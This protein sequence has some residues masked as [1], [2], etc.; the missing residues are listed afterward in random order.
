MQVS[1]QG[2]VR[3]SRRRTRA[4]A[5]AMAL[6]TTVAALL[7]SAGVAGAA[8][9]VGPVDPASGF[10]FSYT[11]DSD[12]LTLQQCQ[13]GSA[14]CI[15]APRPD[16]A[17]PI[18]VPD[19][20]SPDGEGFWWVAD[21]TVPNAGRGLARFAKESAFDN[22]EISLGHQVAFSRIRFRFEGLV[23]GAS[24]RITHPFGVT[25]LVAEDDPG[26]PGTGRINFTNDAGCITPPCGAF[27]AVA[28]DPITGLL[29]W[30]SSAPQIT[31]ADYVGDPTI[32]HAVQGSPEGTNFVQ[33][34]RLLPPAVPGGD[35]TPELVG[36]TDTFLVQGKLAG[37]PPDPAPHL[38]MSDASLFL[39]DRE[40]GSPGPSKTVTITNHGTADLHVSSVRVGG[41]D[42]SDF[43]IVSEDCAGATLAPAET[44]EIE[45][46][47]M[48]AH[49]GNRSAFIQ[50]ES[51]SLGNPHDVAL[52]GNGRAVSAPPGGSPAASGGVTTI[53]QQ[54]IPATTAPQATVAGVLQRSLAVREL[55]AANRITVAR[56]RS[57]GL[58]FA[59]RLPRGVQVL[60]IAIYRER[61]GHRSGRALVRA[62]R[63]PG[64]SGPYVVHMR[65]REIVRRLRPGRY[66]VEVTP[67]RDV[68]DL[69]ATS[70]V[71]FQVVP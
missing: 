70:R 27:P 42:A 14:F 40:V 32:E 51:D 19:N 23:T 7:F 57:K 29:R 6:C 66:L 56:L 48:A 17:A 33:L 52:Q 63:L 35:P 37:D 55:S 28:G 69:G 31:N 12:G 54:F 25:E 22:D 45:A 11:D 49:A 59:M 53:I 41:N 67:G 10:P 1:T 15:E 4:V 24:Y 62:L 38:G 3:V 21:A 64:A 18:S 34:E 50:I 5:G 9:T 20:Y 58:R 44:C 13:D 30:D 8:V 16:T 2:T 26:A 46:R 65:S 60:R 43:A 68:D 47:F 61:D 36:R 71:R 39:G